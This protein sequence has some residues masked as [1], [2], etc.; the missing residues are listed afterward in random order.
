MTWIDHESEV[1]ELCRA[2]AVVDLQH[3]MLISEPLEE[4][5]S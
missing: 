4:V 2:T 3:F 1:V 5:Y